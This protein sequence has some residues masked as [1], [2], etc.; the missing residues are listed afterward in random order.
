MKSNLTST[1]MM[2][3][4]SAVVAIS[5]SSF[6][7]ASNSSMSILG[8]SNLH[9]W[10]SDVCKLKGKANIVLNDQYVEKIENLSFTIPVE[11]IESG[12]GI[13][14][15]KTYTALKSKEHPNIEYKLTT[16]ETVNGKVVKAKGLLTVAGVTQ[17]MDF[18]VHCVVNSNHVNIKGEIV[19]KMTDFNVSPP[20]ALLGTL[21]TGDE[22]TISFSINFVE[23]N[24]L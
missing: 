17:K 23:L 4:F 16:F 10:E 21:K 13:M 5:Q 19:F 12:N 3:L 14:D 1:I 8:T 9:D 18:P 7:I 24:S 11:S 2:L 22:V 6:E 15:G 20:T